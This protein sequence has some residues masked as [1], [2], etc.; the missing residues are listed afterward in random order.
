M[1]IIVGGKNDFRQ[2]HQTN[3]LK[4]IKNPTPYKN[5]F[6]DIS[7]S[8]YNDFAVTV[9]ENHLPYGIGNNKN[10]SMLPYR[11]G[12]LKQF[13][14]IHLNNAPP[15]ESA[16]CGLNYTLFQF[17]STTKSGEKSPS[18]LGYVFGNDKKS[19]FAYLNT[20]GYEIISIYGG[21]Q[22]S[23]AI[24]ECGSIHIIE[25]SIFNDKEYST[26]VTWLPESD[27]PVFIAFQS[28]NILA[29]SSRGYVYEY[30]MSDLNKSDY[31]HVVRELYGIQCVS[32]SGIHE[33]S[34]VVASDGTVYGRGSNRNNQ[35]GIDEIS[36][37]RFVEIASLKD[38]NIT[39]VFAGAFHSFFVD[40]VGAL[41]VCGT[42]K[43]GEAMLNEAAVGKFIEKPILTSITKG[44]RFCVVGTNLSIVFLKA[45]P[46][47]NSNR[48]IEL[49]SAFPYPTLCYH[50]KS[51]VSDV[52]S[53]IE[54]ELFEKDLEIKKLIEK[55]GQ[56]SNID[57]NKMMIRTAQTKMFRLAKALLTMY[58]ND[59]AFKKFKVDQTLK[60]YINEEDNASNEGKKEENDKKVENVVDKDSNANDD[61]DDDDQDEYS[62]DAPEQN[63]NIN[64]NDANENMNDDD[65]DNNN[66]D[67]EYDDNEKDFL[68]DF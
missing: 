18:Y 61:D 19:D 63:N 64:D 34:L 29:L 38:K 55:I 7:L 26:K 49:T 23:A 24:D 45:P 43:F 13:F 21:S 68:E 62:D 9:G 50:S 47:N 4:E 41:Y 46:P 33:H 58:S 10:Q 28:K 12:V 30:N 16:V 1:S 66:D 6:N 22:I 35:L 36:A 52:L 48:K 3:A 53:S 57:K 42:N 20:Q 60:K 59:E 5:D 31:F 37:P 56:I 32:I 25:P 44:V 17:S 2:I 40:N 51:D 65:D 11:S 15:A 8:V 27:L 67:E 54:K 39:S 14:G